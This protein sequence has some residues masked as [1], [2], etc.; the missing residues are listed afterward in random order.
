M[1]WLTVA[2]SASFERVE[3]V[4]LR[5]DGSVAAFAE[6]PQGAQVVFNAGEPNELSVS[7]RAAVI[8]YIATGS[9]NWVVPLSAAENLFP[10]SI[11]WSPDGGVVVSGIFK[12]G[13]SIQPYELRVGDGASA[14]VFSYPRPADDLF[15]PFVVS[16]DAAGALRWV[17]VDGGGVLLTDANRVL[18]VGTSL[19]VYDHAGNVVSQRKLVQAQYEFQAGFTSAAWLPA[20]GFVAAGAFNA[21]ATLE[22]GTPS[23]RPLV[24][25]GNTD[26]VIT[27]YAADGSFMSAVVF[28]EAS[29]VRRDVV[30][31]GVQAD[32]STL[33]AL[34]RTESQTNRSTSYL[35]RLDASDQRVWSRTLPTAAIYAAS[36]AEG[37]VF[38]GGTINMG[39]EFP[40]D[41]TDAKVR[42]GTTDGASAGYVARYTAAGRLETITLLPGA[43][44][45]A[46][47]AMDRQTFIAG[48]DFVGTA[49]FG[50]GAGALERT[51]PPGGDLFV[52][53]MTQLAAP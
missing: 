36:V 39:A 37:A 11:A 9:L 32:G 18:A 13:G 12:H 23:E 28:P 8:S 46:L 35:E 47:G 27:R 45:L 40:V 21:A 33:L 16:F 53:K 4:A 51:A 48:G 26:G 20:G 50:S 31:I 24:L 43:T 7:G 3:R 29:G 30:E 22:P 44:T 38:I 1:E 5:A 15:M 19:T 6:M 17:K 25:K 49:R 41:G 10:G 14:Q 2:G 52:A 42:V 34:R